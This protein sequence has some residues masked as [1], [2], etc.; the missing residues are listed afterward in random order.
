MAS[1]LS[2]RWKVNG[3]SIWLAHFTV[4]PSWLHSIQ[5]A[6][7]ML[8]N[9]TTS[10]S[11]SPLQEYPYSALY[12]V[13][14]SEIQVKVSASFRNTIILHQGH[15]RNRIAFVR[16]GENKN[17]NDCVCDNEVLSREGGWLYALH[18]LGTYCSTPGH[19][20]HAKRL[21]K[22][23]NIIW[24]STK[25]FRSSLQCLKNNGLLLFAAAH[26]H[27]MGL[28]GFKVTAPVSLFFVCLWL[29]EPKYLPQLSAA[30][31]SALELAVTLSFSLTEHPSDEPGLNTFQGHTAPRPKLHTHIGLF[32]LILIVSVEV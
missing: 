16:G 18:E 25:I 3:C 24:H 9:R 29:K 10:Q 23:H 32:T 21:W 2:C 7:L 28:M 27:F 20:S 14:V 22:L 8:K 15:T 26:M 5:W 30:A 17:K 11:V 6:I 19:F 13:W 1:V 4:W 12:K 31:W